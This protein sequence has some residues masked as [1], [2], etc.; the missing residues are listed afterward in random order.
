ASIAGF[1]KYIGAQIASTQSTQPEAEPPAQHSQLV[2]LN[3]R[4]S[5]A[6]LFCMHPSGGRATA[7]LR[8][9]T[10]LGDDQPLYALQSQALHEPNT[11][12][13]TI[14]SMAAGYAAVV[15]SVRPD[16]PYRLVGWSMGG[17]IAL[18]VA[19]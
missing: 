15:Q 12:H 17:L 9:R 7:Y 6:P 5:Q 18:A 13:A 11:E 8:L 1:A 4:G 10:L 16:G 2:V 14:E 3:D 19:S